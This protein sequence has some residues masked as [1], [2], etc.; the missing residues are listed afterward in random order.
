MANKL[1]DNS[2]GEAFKEILKNEDIESFSDYSNNDLFVETCNI[3][4]NIK[5]LEDTSILKMV[6]LFKHF[7]CILILIDIF[8]KIVKSCENNENELSN[9]L[10][11]YFESESTGLEKVINFYHLSHIV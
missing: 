9:K 3:L 7:E 11:K 6:I 1:N 2:V 8:I 10:V 4:K 5:Y